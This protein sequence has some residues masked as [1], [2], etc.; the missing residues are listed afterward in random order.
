VCRCRSAKER[1]EDIVKGGRIVVSIQWPKESYDFV[2][3]LREKVEKWVIRGRYN[4]QGSGPQ[5]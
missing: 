2:K 1:S 3:E 4:L 5:L